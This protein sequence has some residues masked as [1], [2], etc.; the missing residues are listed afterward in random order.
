MQN[1][2]LPQGLL[3]GGHLAANFMNVHQ[4]TLWKLPGF[5]FSDS[6]P[7]SEA[8]TMVTME[9]EAWD[10]CKSFNTMERI[11]NYKKKYIHSDV[12]V[13]NFFSAPTLLANTVTHCRL[14]KSIYLCQPVAHIWL[15]KHTCI[16]ERVICG[17]C[18]HTNIIFKTQAIV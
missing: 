5:S 17:L 1:L 4:V 3:R 6:K 18:L 10:R 15:I 11:T 8:E 14:L 12:L 7:G 16:S 13:I 2:C 9:I